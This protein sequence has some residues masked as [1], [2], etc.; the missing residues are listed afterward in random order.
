MRCFSQLYVSRSFI[1]MHAFKLFLPHSLIIHSGNWGSVGHARITMTW[2]CFFACARLV[3]KMARSQSGRFS[4]LRL[5]FL[6]PHV[7][8]ES[9]RTACKM[10]IPPVFWG[11]AS[12][13][14][15]SLRASQL[16]RASEMGSPAKGSMLGG[17]GGSSLSSGSLGIWAW[18]TFH[19]SEVG[20]SSSPKGAQQRHNQSGWLGLNMKNRPQSTLLE[21]SWSHASIVGMLPSSTAWSAHSDFAAK[22]FGRY[23]PPLEESSCTDPFCCGCSGSDSATFE[24]TSLGTSGTSS[25]GTLSDPVP[26]VSVESGLGCAKPLESKGSK[27]SV[28]NS[29]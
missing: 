2:P 20:P 15:S 22:I 6:F 1:F 27:D 11:R 25:T 21:T 24:G 13:T 10:M 14:S 29:Q 9:E 23:F 16:G 28:E 17:V 12:R 4:S 5:S 3:A 7:L 8:L 18:Y 19:W 26:A